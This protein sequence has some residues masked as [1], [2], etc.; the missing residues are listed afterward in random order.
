MSTTQRPRSD[1]SDL[2]YTVS[3]YSADGF[4]LEYSNLILMF[5]VITFQPLLSS[6]LLSNLFF[7][8]SFSIS[9]FIMGQSP[10]KIPNHVVE[11]RL[12]EFKAFKT[13]GTKIV[14]STT[15]SCEKG[16]IATFSAPNGMSVTKKIYV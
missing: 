12:A 5:L 4:N 2:I 6:Q 15:I 14:P 3:T 1:T 11:A 8:H 9:T 16:D 13:N 7:T 10:S